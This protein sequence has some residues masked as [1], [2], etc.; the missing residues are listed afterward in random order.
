MDLYVDP[1]LMYLTQ[2]E[3]CRNALFCCLASQRFIDD[4]QCYSHFHNMLAVDGHRLVL[5]GC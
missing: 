4:V 1:F 5:A 2:T 3:G